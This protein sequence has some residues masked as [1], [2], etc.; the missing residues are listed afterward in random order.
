MPPARPEPR[1]IP[2]EKEALLWQDDEGETLSD[3]Y[4][5]VYRRA[6]YL[7]GD[8]AAAEDTAQ[9]TFLRYLTRKPQG[10][11][12]PAAWLATV[13]TR[14]C[15]DWMRSGRRRSVPLETAAQLTDAAPLPEEIVSDREELALVR[16]ALEHLHPRDRMVLLLRHSNAS[17]REIA[18]AVGVAESSVGPLLHRAERRFRDAY[19]RLAAG[20][21]P[22]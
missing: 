12:N 3:L 5:A 14:L 4:P 16:A 1:A 8:P 11:R 9:E 17:Y 19:R 2:A 15:Y 20:R 10:L 18:A 7:T 22:R 6:L 21:P 13:C